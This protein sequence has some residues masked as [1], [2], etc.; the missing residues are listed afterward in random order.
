MSEAQEM[1]LYAMMALMTSGI[2]ES[3][4]LAIAAAVWF[5]L[6]LTCKEKA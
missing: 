2:T 5:L 4:G 6:S 1:R 3:F